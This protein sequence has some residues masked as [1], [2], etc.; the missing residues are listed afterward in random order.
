MRVPRD[1]AAPGCP[2]DGAPDACGSGAAVWG[3]RPGPRA[4]VA[5]PETLSTVTT[6][7][8]LKSPPLT[9]PRL[10]AAAPPPA[11]RPRDPNAAPRAL[12][13]PAVLARGCPASGGTATQPVA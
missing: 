5:A 6:R 9:S 10:R 11:A 4:R 12:L 8:N 13:Y 1:A 3:C 2:A 7:P